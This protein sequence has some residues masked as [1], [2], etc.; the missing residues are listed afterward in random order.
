MSDIE[1]LADDL[2]EV[3]EVK[4]EPKVE[5]APEPKA[6]QPKEPAQVATTPE[7]ALAPTQDN[8]PEPGHVP[9]VALLDEREKRRE[10]EKRLNALESQA[11][12]QA[13][14]AQQRQSIPDP[15]VDPQAYSQHLHQEMDAMRWEISTTQSKIM[16]EQAYD[17]KLVQEAAESF[18]AETKA[19]PWLATELRQQAH[20]YDWVVR[21]Y[22]REQV[23]N[24]IDSSE[25]DQFKAWKAAQAQ[26]Q[27]Q[28]GQP[29]QS[30]A[31]PPRSLASL[32]SAGGNKPGDVMN[33]PDQVFAA[34]IK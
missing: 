20:P 28:T 24:G 5:T 7:P 31:A 10:A 1:S 13:Q 34:V 25:I 27:A 16:A 23:L 32:P 26:A 15:R 30:M 18:V 33:T 19:R 14:R 17:P 12:E 2:P 3:Q 8:R 21:R 22:Q 29:P 11:R 4:A 9:I 6:E